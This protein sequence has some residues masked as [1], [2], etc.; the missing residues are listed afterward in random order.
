MTLLIGVFTY[1]SQFELVSP[2]AALI[3]V[4]FFMAL[5]SIT[6]ILSIE[7][8]SSSTFFN[9]YAILMMTTFWVSGFYLNTIRRS[10]S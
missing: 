6:G 8:L 10:S 1:T 9:K 5:G 4:W 7:G 3:I 2:G